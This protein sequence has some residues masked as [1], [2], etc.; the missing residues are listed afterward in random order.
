MSYEYSRDLNRLPGK[1]TS[2][3]E[4]RRQIALVQRETEQM[5]R[6]LKMDIE[7]LTKRVQTLE[8]GA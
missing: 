4:L 2:P 5:I 7:A 3:D 1:E 6:Q 8:G